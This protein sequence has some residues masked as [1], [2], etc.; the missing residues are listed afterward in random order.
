[1]AKRQQTPNFEEALAELEEIV[2]KME[3]GDLKLDQSLQAFER[4][5]QLARQCQTALKDAEQKVTILMQKEGKFQL[6]PFEND[7]DD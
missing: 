6:E 4:G 2:N 5:V 1:M 7:N 3:Q